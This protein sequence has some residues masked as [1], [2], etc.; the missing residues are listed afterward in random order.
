MSLN[1]INTSVRDEQK[2]VSANSEPRSFDEMV[3]GAIAFCEPLGEDF[4]AYG[5]Q[6]FELKT[7][8]SKGRLH[9]AVLGQFNR[10]KSTFINALL[11]MKTLPTSVLP[12][13]SVPTIIEYGT[14]QSCKIRFLNGKEDL[15]VNECAQRIENTLRQFVAEESNPQNRF[16]VKDAVVT[17]GSPLLSN[18][19]V[20]IDTPGFGSTHLHNTQ[21][22]LD[23]LAECDAALFLLSADPPMTQTEMEFL[24]QVKNYVPKLFF[25]LNKVDLLTEDGLEEVDTFIKKILNRELGITDDQIT[26]FH[27]S[28]RIAM[29]A[30][31]QD[32]KDESWA[33]SGIEELKKTV[34]DFMI[35]EKYFTLSEALGDKYKETTGAVKTLLEKKLNEKVTPLESAQQVLNAL[36]EDVYAITHEQESVIKACT[37]KKNELKGQVSNWKNEHPNAHRLS[38]EKVLELLLNGTYFPDEAASIAATVLPKQACDLGV[39]L[40]GS[41]IDSV[42]RAIRALI[43]KHTETLSH[44]QSQISSENEETPSSEKLISQLE[45]S[46]G[47][48]YAIFDST[49][50]TAPAPQM[51][52]VF[53]KKA[54]RFQAIEDYYKPLCDQRVMQDIDK[55]VKH[56]NAAIETAWKN[57]QDNLS[58]PYQKLI[59]S[60][61]LIHKLKHDQFEKDRGEVKAEIEFLRAKLNEI[62][63]IL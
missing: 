35:R 49:P 57:L 25:A 53:R 37:E 63:L 54:L 41:L 51:R 13:T 30:A 31:A 61:K 6:L 26:L 24:R 45:I 3:K 48:L 27:T 43:I 16:G 19:T 10:G 21:T 8:L 7:R 40:L 34:L 32:L 15:I 12:L 56:A 47:D 18:G 11:G 58:A 22:T 1:K 59:D 4:T 9:F 44:L 17:C 46:A 55:A 5:K 33:K 23:L 60:T 20:L 62:I 38:I 29:Q 39:Q 2:N 50:F 52:D 14:K 36:L 42:N 28:A